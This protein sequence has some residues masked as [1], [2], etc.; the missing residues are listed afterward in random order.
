VR[1]V[2]RDAEAAPSGERLDE[3]ACPGPGLDAVA[4]LAEDEL[5]ELVP[6][7][8][9]LARPVE[10]ALEDPAA[11]LGRRTEELRLLLD[12][13]GASVPREELRLGARPQTLGVEQEA[14]AVEDDR[15]YGRR[16]P[17]QRNLFPSPKY[18]E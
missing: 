7:R 12:A 4:E 18:A 17:A 10:E 11:R 8:L 15:P 1:R 6:E 13:E 2:R 14:V 16:S 5:V 9:G 3:L